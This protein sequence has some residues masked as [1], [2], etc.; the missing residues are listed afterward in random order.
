MINLLP[1]DIKSDIAYA[2]K[3]TVLIRWIT[4][5]VFVIIGVFFVVLVGQLYLNQS[6]KTYAS[7]I[8]EGK[9]QLKEQKLEET[10][11]RA[12]EISDNVKLAVNVLSKQ[13]LF[14]KVVTQI[15]KVMPDGTVLTGLSINQLSGGI[16]LIARAKDYNTASQVQLNLQDPNNKIFEKADIVSTECNSTPT[17]DNL[18][19]TTYPCRITVRALF[20]KNNSF[21]FID[22]D[23]K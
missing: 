10:Q 13:I 21:L 14:S 11:A 17:T 15:G 4:A 6:K 22:K 5:F 16:D 3:N 23:K 12:Q 1:P 2:R 19:E 20:A 8:D 9:T 18:V 7:Q